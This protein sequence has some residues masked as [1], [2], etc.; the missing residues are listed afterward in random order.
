MVAAP[1]VGRFTVKRLLPFVATNANRGEV[2]DVVAASVPH[3]H[4]MMALYCLVLA[5]AI[6]AMDSA[7]YATPLVSLIYYAAQML[8][9]HRFCPLLSG[10][11][12]AASPQVA[13][14]S[15]VGLGYLLL[16]FEGVAKSA[17]NPLEWRWAPLYAFGLGRLPLVRFA[18]LA[19]CLF[20]GFSAFN[21]RWRVR[22]FP[23][24]DKRLCLMILYK[25]SLSSPVVGGGKTA[26]ASTRAAYSLRGPLFFGWRVC[27]PTSPKFLKM[28]SRVL[29]SGI[30]FL[31][32]LDLVRLDKPSTVVGLPT[33]SAFTKAHE[34]TIAYTWNEI[35]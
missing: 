20:A 22:P 15:L 9:F 19:S 10:W 26:A 28:L 13:F 14:V 8:P 27:T 3:W 30:P 32:Q 24:A 4:Y 33:T 1:K 17:A 23:E 5:S 35:Y 34:K 7:Y 18:Q 29:S 11:E 12:R 6:S 2:A 31:H 16:R 21:W 25:F